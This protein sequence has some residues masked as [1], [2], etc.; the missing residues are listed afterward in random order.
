MAFLNG[1]AS[2]QRFR[3]DGLKVA[4]GGDHLDQFREHE[5]GSW[6]V[7]AADGVEVGWTA[8]KHV[9]DTA[10]GLEM[11]VVAEA[12]CVTTDRPP[13]AHY[14]T[15]FLV[16]GDL[17]GR[18]L[19]AF[20]YASNWFRTHGR[21][22]AGLLQVG[23]LGYFPNPAAMDRATVRHAK[24]GSLE[25]GTLDIVTP[26]P[27]RRR[28]VRGRPAR[29]AEAVVHGWQPRGLQR[30]RT[31]RVRR[32]GAGLRGRCVR[33]GAGHQGRADHGIRVRSDRRGV[34]GINGDEPNCRRK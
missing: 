31:A 19:L 22:L 4:S 21:P 32:A 6:T 14:P 23:D 29:P 8:G 7:A 16:F 17:H 11:N 12:Q 15:T 20:Q 18:V 33:P 26:E 24:D 28:R 5:F 30:T 13:A 25:L 2:F 1:R 10:F 9:R 27:A 3:G 34:W